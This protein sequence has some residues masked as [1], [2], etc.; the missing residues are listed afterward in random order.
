MREE[1]VEC[2]LLAGSV[3]ARTLALGDAPAGI[4]GEP[5]GMREHGA[6]AALGARGV[7]QVI[8]VQLRRCDECGLTR[9]PGPRRKA[10][11]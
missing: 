5:T 1:G 6:E 9:E 2:A 7:V 3:A 10:A 4:L 11:S 8:E